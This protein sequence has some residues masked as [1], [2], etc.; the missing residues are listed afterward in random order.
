[1]M[2]MS[3]IENSIK[4]AITL[5]EALLCFYLVFSFFV[6]GCD[7][8]FVA[9]CSVLYN[10]S[11]EIMKLCRIENKT[12]LLKIYVNSEQSWNYKNTYKF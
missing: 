1:M 3:I 12:D 10:S 6:D 7:P 4:Y 5:C 2:C 9:S 8:C 11:R